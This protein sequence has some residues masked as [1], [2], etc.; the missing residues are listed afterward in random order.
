MLLHAIR[1]MVKKIKTNFSVSCFFLIFLLILS[2]TLF[3]E[4]GPLRPG[5][6]AEPSHLHTKFLKMDH[7]LLWLALED[8][9]KV[10]MK[11]IDR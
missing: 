6:L 11:Y 3:L 9:E 2:H 8:E 5:R 1:E 10:K 7:L 4:L